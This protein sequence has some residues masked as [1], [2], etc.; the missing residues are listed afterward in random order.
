MKLAPLGDCL[1]AH[2]CCRLGLGGS[3]LVAL[4]GAVDGGAG[5]ADEVA[6]FGGAVLAGIVQGDQMCFLPGVELGLLATKPP[7]GLGDLHA[8]AGAQPD[9]VRFKLGD[10]RQDVEQQPTNRDGRVMQ[11]AAE[12]EF[13]LPAGEVVDDSRASGSERARRSSL[14]MTSVSPS[15]Q[16]AIA[17]RSPGR[18]RLVPVRPWST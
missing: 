17:S 14:V 1:P 9:Q 18:S 7:F 5:D 11:G 15:R 4:D 6:E 12:A 8:L 2:S 3:G 10:H 16:A 13:D